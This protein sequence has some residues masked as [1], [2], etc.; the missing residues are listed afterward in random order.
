MVKSYYITAMFMRKKNIILLALGYLW[1]IAV[2]MKFSQKNATET[3]KSLENNPNF[4][5]VFVEN[6]VSMH[7]DI[8]K[9][10]EQRALSDENMKRLDEYK[11][12]AKKEVDSFKK[13]AEKKME[14]L[15]KQWIKKK[16]EVEKELRKIYDRRQEYFDETKDTAE[17]Y[18]EEGVE[19]AKEYLQDWRK[20]LEKAFEDIKKKIGK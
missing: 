8:Y 12:R 17:E 6:V 4:F 3:K 1:G 11:A 15:K 10:F 14:E 16:D 18:M 20:K 13:E 2:A 7:K 9:Y 19:L 5:D